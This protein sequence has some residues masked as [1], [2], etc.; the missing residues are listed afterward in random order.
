[1]KNRIKRLLRE[2][3]KENKTQYQ[4]RYIDGAIFYKRDS[5]E[6]KWKFI[7]DE[8]FANNVCDG[9]LIKWDEKQK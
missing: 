7:T 4:I 5:S 2:S 9:E 6:E 8:E 1:M 3:T